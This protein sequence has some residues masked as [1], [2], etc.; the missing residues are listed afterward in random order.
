MK[1]ICPECSFSRE[2]PDHKIPARTRV[3]TCPKCGHRFQ[4]RD[5]AEPAD[6]PEPST[7]APKS[8]VPGTQE[9]EDISTSPTPPRQEPAE[10]IWDSLSAM[11]PSS[12][13]SPK[14]TSPLSAPKDPTDSLPSAENVPWENLDRF[15]FFPGFFETIKRVMLHP[16]RF[17]SGL[18]FEPGIG[19]PLIF[20]LLIA[21][22]QA[23]AQFFWQMSGV[24]PMMTN[25]PGG[26]QVG[27]GMM[28]M[29]SAFILIM[30]PLILTVML[31]IMVGVNHLCLLLFKAADRGFS[32]T[33]RAVTYG[34]APMVLALIPL[35]GPV[36]GAL[37]TMTTTFFGYKYIHRTTTTRVV[38]AMLLPL[39]VMTALVGV[40]LLTNGLFLG[41]A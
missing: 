4:F 13:H 14:D 28:G 3:A 25:T 31:F 11:Q 32:G 24:V 19:K 35:I 18:M 36:I 40:M 34:S 33:F 10:D 38:L 9:S 6:T 39:L 1:I 16:I 30:Y 21:E 15:G 27:L 29:G 37:W 17:F 26:S 7:E 20:Y 5:I 23:L 12:S 41:N 8:T 22:V 2:I